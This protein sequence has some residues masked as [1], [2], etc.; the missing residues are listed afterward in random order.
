MNQSSESKNSSCQ[1]KRRTFLRN[2]SLSLAGMSALNANALSVFAKETG[3]KDLYKEDFDIGVAIGA[4]TFMQ[5]D[6]DML[7]L[8]AREFNSITSENNMKWSLIHPSENE[9]RFEIPDQ[10][11]EFGIKNNMHMLGHVLV[12]HSQVPAEIFKDSQG[13]QVSKK[14]LLKRMET[15]IFTVVNRYK[16]KI[17]AWDVVNESITPEEGWRKSP[18]LEIIGP[19]FM[20][21]AFHLAHEADP[22]CHLLYNDYGMY[23]PK[24]R[25]FVV[26]VVKDFKKKGVPIHGIGMQG[27]Y[28]IDSPNIR[29]IE[30]S[31]E[32]FASTGLRVHFTELDVDVLPYDW[33]RTAE[34]STNI[35]YSQTLNPY[36]D[37]LPK[38]VNDKLTRR[39]EELFKLFL[40]HRDKIDRV[41]F[42]GTTDAESWKN[43]F[44]MRGRTNY[45][46]LFDRERKRKDAYYAVAN[47]KQ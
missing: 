17:H 40:K 23:N 41:T 7:N 10:F 9:W 47:L 34:I 36:V 42:W 8:I 3:L 25:D 13:N 38:E 14:V 43:N 33:S 16:G 28:N 39:Y 4:R 29:E 21:H 46:L 5:N 37:G 30:K 24:R 6:T 32:A 18:W 19:E 2:V 15:H 11:V 20:D 27:H 1:I 22:D 12:W 45:P 31:I 26:E 35:E 44:P